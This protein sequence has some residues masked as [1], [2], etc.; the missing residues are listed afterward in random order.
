[1]VCLNIFRY[2]KIYRKYY[3]SLAKYNFLWLFVNILGYFLI[4]VYSRRLIFQVLNLTSK[5]VAFYCSNFVGKLHG[6]LLFM[7][8]QFV[9]VWCKAVHFST[10]G[11]QHEAK[12]IAKHKMFLCLEKERK[13][14]GF[15]CRLCEF[16]N[17][18]YNTYFFIQT[19]RCRNKSQY[20]I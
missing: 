10:I 4:H 11:R 5:D 15:Q 9:K 16:S 7:A 3:Q 8:I 19:D 18:T 20:E 17:Q 1:M 6:F 13:A 14:T 2:H 12:W